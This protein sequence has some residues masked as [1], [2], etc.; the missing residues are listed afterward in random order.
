MIADM[1]FTP[2]Q[3]RKALRESVSQLRVPLELQLT[4]RGVIQILPSDGYSTI[5]AM[6]VRKNK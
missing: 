5:Q 4:S 1:G 6:L 3:A 2:A